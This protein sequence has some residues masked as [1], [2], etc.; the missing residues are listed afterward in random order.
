MGTP[1][2]K[3]LGGWE[4]RWWCQLCY[5]LCTK[6]THV[7]THTHTYP[8]LLC[9]GSLGSQS[10]ALNKAFLFLPL[11]AGSICHWGV[12]FLISGL[13]ESGGVGVEK[14]TKWM[15]L[16]T[17]EIKPLHLH[18]PVFPPAGTMLPRFSSQNIELFPTKL[19]EGL[20][21][22]QS[23]R[24]NML[25]RLL[26]NLR[27]TNRP[28]FCFRHERNSALK[29]NY[30]VSAEPRCDLAKCFLCELSNLV[31]QP[32][33]CQ[34]HASVMILLWL[35]SCPQNRT[36]SAEVMLRSGS[37]HLGSFRCAP[38]ACSTAISAETLT[39]QHSKAI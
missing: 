24:Q 21:D 3:G 25:G 11:I 8:P 27:W 14:N 22:T 7:C 10:A 16:L 5:W 29:D 28:Y 4:K 23:N 32:I 19:G 39:A 1:G 9:E 17:N 36:C 30:V 6:H 26:Q 15:H 33:F 20:A 2:E 37:A 13:T 12:Q 35:F 34:N 18:F 31:H 38:L